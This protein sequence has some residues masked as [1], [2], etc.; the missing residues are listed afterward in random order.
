MQ[1]NPSTILPLVL[2]VFFV[3]ILGASA[4]RIIKPNQRGLVVRLGRYQRTCSPGLTIIVPFID[5]LQ[6]V[7]VRE[8]VIDVPSQS[9]ITKDNVGVE[10]DAIIYCQVTDPFKATYEIN[11]YTN[12]AVKLAQ[13]SLRNTLG[14]MELDQSLTSRET[15][16][17]QLRMVL[18]DATGKWGIKVNRVEIQRIDPPKDITE[19]MSRQMKAE[20]DKRAAILE[21]EGI[22]LANITKAEGLKQAAILESEGK[23][24]AIQKIADAE[25]YR[26]I[27]EASGEA[28]AT[29]NVFTA[30]HKG[31]P[32]DKLI[33][34][35]YLETLQSM[36][37]GQASKIFIPYEA[38]ALLSG[39]GAIKEI[40]MS[41][42][43]DTT[44]A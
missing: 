42:S 30:I 20:R 6:A 36:A 5:K 21:A 2:I 3:F 8:R 14:E 23:A 28:E 25:K 33:T 18:D 38:S 40:L 4:I 32:D 39:L 31:E 29:I 27:T 12:A 17:T 1:A 34:L 16:N 26:R 7:D 44:K 10:V 11:D 13:T 15:I 9:I 24:N 35:K 41:K 43:S 19:A 37:N 22:K